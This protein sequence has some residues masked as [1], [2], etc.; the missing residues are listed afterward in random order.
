MPVDIYPVCMPSKGMTGSFLFFLWDAPRRLTLAVGLSASG[1]CL[2]TGAGHSD[3]VKRATSVVSLAVWQ[4][5]FASVTLQ[6]C[7]R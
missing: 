1:C 2:S 6:L 5:A 4:P 3:L 7:A